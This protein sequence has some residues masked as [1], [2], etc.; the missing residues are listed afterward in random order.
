MSSEVSINTYEVSL[1]L[2]CKMSCCSLLCWFHTLTGTLR[3]TARQRVE[4]AKKHRM[5]S[6]TTKLLIISSRK[7]LIN[8]S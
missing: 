7:S 6:K 5:Q 8:T 1:T 2:L 3:P 4:G